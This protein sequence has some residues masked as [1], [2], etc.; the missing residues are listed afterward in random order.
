MPG[1]RGHLTG[2]GAVYGVLFAILYSYC[3]TPFV[4]VRWL[5][6]ALAGS[7]F[8]DIDIK[9]KG[10]KYFYWFFLCLLLV[11]IAEKQYQLLAMCSVLSIT[12]M[13]VNHRG[14]FHRSWFVI[15]VPLG[16]WVA[17]VQYSSVSGETYF[18]DLLFFIGGALSHIF[19]DSGVR[20]IFRVW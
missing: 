3:T 8:P 18:F 20:G 14:I 9:S 2:G 4:A 15:L 13:L 17:L 10:Q 12:P 1:Y 5:L 6:F 16:I 19:L 7:L 11:I